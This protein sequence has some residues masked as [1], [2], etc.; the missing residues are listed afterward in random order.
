M[1]TAANTI[2]VTITRQD[3]TT[4]TET[5]DNEKKA[6]SFCREEVKWEST[7]RV[8]CPA[9]EF[10]QEGDYASTFIA[11]ME[12]QNAGATYTMTHEQ[13][14]AA[15]AG[16]DLTTYKGWIAA[17]EALLAAAPEWTAIREEGGFVVKHEG[18]IYACAEHRDADA[19]Y[20]VEDDLYD[21]DA[22]A[23]CVNAWDGMTEA[24]C[25]ASLTNPVFVSLRHE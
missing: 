21:F 11:A 13:V 12:K 22:S 6:R 25:T 23:W 2:I 8:V 1:N 10:D 17:A 24:K 18:G 3:G 14:Q 19:I 9:I 4:E 15:I 7:A 16:H 20:S 5:F